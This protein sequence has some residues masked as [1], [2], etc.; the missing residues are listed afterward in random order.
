M[1]GRATCGTARAMPT[2]PTPTT[3]SRIWTSIGGCSSGPLGRGSSARAFVPYE[4]PSIGYVDGLQAQVHPGEHTRLGIAG[5]L[6]PDRIN[7]D[8]STDEPFV[9]PYATYVAGPRDGRHY[10]GTVGLMNSYYQ[11][12]LDR[13]AVLFDQRAGLSKSLTLIPRRS[14]TSMWGPPRRHR[15]EAD[16]VGRIRCFAAFVLSDPAGGCGSLGRPDHQAGECPPAVPGRAVLRQR[17]LALLG[18]QQP[19]H[20]VEP[21][22]VRGSGYITSDT[23]DGGV[24][25]CR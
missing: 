20:A 10:S 25:C 6:K 14:W 19:E 2:C 11:G 15:D 7:L 4:L 18:G 1:T 12:D 21:A 24:R 3:R 13:L 22:F 9:V 8:P 16:P 17:L 23:V 5:G